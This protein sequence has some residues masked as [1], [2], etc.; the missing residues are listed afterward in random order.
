MIIIYD[1]HILIVELNYGVFGDIVI[2]FDIE[3]RNNV[4]GNERNW[5]EEVLLN[6]ELQNQVPYTIIFKY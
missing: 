2:R 1:I 6:K 3:L 5:T 4:I